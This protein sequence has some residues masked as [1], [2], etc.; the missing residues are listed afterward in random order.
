MVYQ[1]TPITVQYGQPYTISF[2]AGQ[3]S[4][5]PAIFNAQFVLYDPN[6]LANYM[7]LGPIVSTGGTSGVAKGTVLPISSDP[8]VNGLHVASSVVIT[9]PS[10]SYRLAISWETTGFS[11]GRD[12]NFDNISFVTTQGNKDTDGDGIYDHLDLDSDND[13]ISDLVESGAS[14]AKVAADTNKDGTVSLAEAAAA[15]SG[16][17]DADS[18]GLMDIFDANTANISTVSSIGTVPLNS[19]SDSLGN[20]RELDSDGDGIP[21][22]VEARAT[23]GY[24]TNDGNVTNNDLDD[25]GVIDQFDSNDATSALF[26][27]TFATPQDTDGDGKPDYLD[28]D[29]DNDGISDQSESGFGFPGYDF[30]GDGIGDTIGATYSDPDGVINVP[31]DNLF[32]AITTT[33]EVAYREFNDVDGD[34]VADAIDIDDDN[35]GLMDVTERANWESEFSTAT[36]KLLDYTYGTGAINVTRTYTSPTGGGSAGVLLSTLMDAGRILAADATYLYILSPTGT[37]D[38]YT[39]SSGLL[40]MG[41]VTTT[42]TGGESGGETIASLVAANRIVGINAGYLYVLSDN[43][44]KIERYTLPTT[45]TGAYS[46][47]NSISTATSLGSGGTMSGTTYVALA[48]QGRIVGVDTTYLYVL[49]TTGAL[50]R[51]NS[52]TGAYAAVAGA[53]TLSGGAMSGESLLTAWQNNRLISANGTN[54]IVFDGHDLLADSDG[55]RIDDRLDLDSDNDG[56]T[57]NVEAQTTKGYIAPS[58]TASLMIDADKDGLDDK[59]DANTTLTTTVASKGLTAVDTESDGIPDYLDLDSDGDGKAD[60]IEAGHGKTLV[61]AD[62]DEDGLQDVFEGSNLNDGYVVSDQNNVVSGSGLT[63]TVGSWNLA[64]S[65]SDLNTT[66]SNAVAL[67]IDFDYREALDTDGDN[68]RD[69]VDIDD[70]NDGILDINEGYIAPTAS[71]I[72]TPTAATSSPGFINQGTADAASSIDGSGLTGSGLSATHAIGD[73]DNEMMWVHPSTKNSITY[74]MASNTYVDSVV[75]WALDVVNYGGGD[76]PLKD[77]TVTAVFKCGASWTSPVFTTVKPTGS[78]TPNYAQIFNLGQRLVNVVSLRITTLNGWYDSTDSDGPYVSTDSVTVSPNYNMTLGEFRALGGTGGGV[79]TDCD[80]APLAHTTSDHLDLDSDNDGIRDLVESGALTTTI[81]YDTNNDGTISLAEA[82]AANGGIADKDG[83]GLMDIFDANVNDISDAASKG[84]V[85]IDSDG[86][87]I[88]NWRDLDSDGDGIPDTVEARPTANFVTNDG[89][90]SNNDLDNDG[91]IDL[92]DS[93]DAT[94]KLFGG[95]FTTLNDDDGDGKPDYLDLD[96]DGDGKLDS[97]ESGLTPGTDANKDGIGD[98]VGA[99]YL[100]PGWRGECPWHVSQER[101]RRFHRNRLP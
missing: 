20:W 84:T 63:S 23:V 26:G 15:N 22:T 24:V 3:S 47:N 68:V 82:A 86:D 53:S 56:I 10:G 25:D 94:T 9:V 41:F 32:D 98:G 101:D 90:V 64:D 21:D 70:D 73:L 17:A 49:S 79:D 72:V 28:L 48:S 80:A 11:S 87:L 89:N 93:N 13:G 58:G 12:M 29:S 4:G 36:L 50:E 8:E 78:G 34:G 51:Y 83:D 95:S 76:A 85:P 52:N 18:D 31:E 37:I 60:I 14:A 97:V 55:D 74:T 77:F 44:G 19:D 75:I 38:R 91:V 67:N 62:A 40:Q 65:D 33:A 42:L 96:S 5:N 54:T 6:N 35:D 16:T 43:S 88:G 30:N 71:G 27:G 45:A 81:A 99:T 100:R 69:E 39:A 92:F 46:Y 7:Y 1:T 61:L 57:D 2:D 66:A 59:Y